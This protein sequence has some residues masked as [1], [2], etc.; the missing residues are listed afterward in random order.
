MNEHGN[1]VNSV[2]KLYLKINKYTKQV[3]HILQ[4]YDISVHLSIRIHRSKNITRMIIQ[5]A[6]HVL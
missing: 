4:T 2:D 1:S 5:H 3:K 6:V